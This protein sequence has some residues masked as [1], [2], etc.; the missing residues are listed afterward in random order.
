MIQH[1]PED[2][3]VFREQYERTRSEAGRQVERLVLG[4]EVGLNGYT[5]VDQA[6]RLSECLNLSPDSV[7]LDLG[8]GRGWPGTYLGWSTQCRVVLSDIPVEALK[9]ARTYAEGRGISR[10]VSCVCAE[11]MTLPFDHDC[12]DGVVHADVFC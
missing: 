5:T 8:A 11:G 7:L 10:L 4:H 6:Q 1:G 3:D 12:F 2:R 9:Q